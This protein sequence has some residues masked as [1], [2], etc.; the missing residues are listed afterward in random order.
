MDL[1]KEAELLAKIC[2]PVYGITFL[3]KMISAYLTTNAFGAIGTENPMP[4]TAML[5]LGFSQAI[6][7]FLAPVALGIWLYV[8]ARAHN[9][10]PLL[11][12]AFGLVA[13]LFAAAIF[14][15]VR[16]HAELSFNKEVVRD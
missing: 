11:W 10:N 6:N 5:F 9:Y 15:L 1:R 4:D 16:A 3:I 14:C 12:G 7:A 13:N 2:I 8:R